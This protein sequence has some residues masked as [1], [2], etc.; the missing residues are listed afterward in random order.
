LPD[1]YK[2]YVAFDILWRTEISSEQLAE[3]VT[4]HNE[5]DRLFADADNAKE[6][7]LHRL[8]EIVGPAVDKK[9]SAIGVAN[10]DS[11]SQFAPSRWTAKIDGI[12][13]GKPKPLVEIR[14]T[15]KSESHLSSD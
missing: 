2:N 9:M 15:N 12:G 13:W 5:V 7:Y 8:R 10:D 3:L 4:I 1:Y 14:A 11:A 6:K